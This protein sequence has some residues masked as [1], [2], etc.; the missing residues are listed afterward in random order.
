VSL[1]HHALDGDAL[2]FFARMLEGRET[3]LATVFNRLEA[4]FSSA[5]RQSNVKSRLKALRLHRYQDD[6]T[7]VDKQKAI[8]LA[9]N[10]IDHLCSQ[11]DP[12]YDTERDRMDCLAKDVLQRE[13]EWCWPAIRTRNKSATATFAD[14]VQELETDLLTAVEH[15]RVDLKTIDNPRQG[16]ACDVLF[17]HRRHDG[18]DQYGEPRRREAPP[19]SHETRRRP[20]FDMSKAVCWRCDKPG[21]LMTQCRNPRRSI[22]DALKAR[23]R[24]LVAEQSLSSNDAVATVLF[25]HAKMMDQVQLLDSE[26]CEDHIDVLEDSSA[27]DTVNCLYLRLITDDMQHRYEPE[28]DFPPPGGFGY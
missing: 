14:F 24:Y 27:S 15:G 20:P 5:D 9:K 1:L 3:Q 19:L 2:K 18:A 28:L 25:Q 26:E 8:Q 23:V 4:Q 13:G 17:Q 21:H 22:Q 12:S 16:E 11:G 10:E 6:D 7:T